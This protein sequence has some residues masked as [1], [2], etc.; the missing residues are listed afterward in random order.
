[1]NN[2]E[3]TILEVSK[4]L[5][6]KEGRFIPSSKNKIDATVAVCSGSKSEIDNIMAE[7]NKYNNK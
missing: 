4:E 6:K 5:A 2:V 1:M 7:V 3:K